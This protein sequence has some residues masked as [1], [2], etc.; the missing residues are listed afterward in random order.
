MGR[1]L[2]FAW[3][4]RIACLVAWVWGKLSADAGDRMI[5]WQ[6]YTWTRAWLDMTDGR[7]SAV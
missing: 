6:I 5:A 2:G 1:S 4:I 3:V 7:T